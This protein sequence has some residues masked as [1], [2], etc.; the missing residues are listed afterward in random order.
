MES[1]IEVTTGAMAT[2]I[3]VSMYP[4]FGTLALRSGFLASEDSFNAESG[5]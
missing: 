5:R 1:R 2:K 3:D 4:F